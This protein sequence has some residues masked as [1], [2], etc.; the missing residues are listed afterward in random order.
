MND[1]EFVV[2]VKLMDSKKWVD[3][4]DDHSSNFEGEQHEAHGQRQKCELWGD[5]KGYHK[6]MNCKFGG[7]RRCR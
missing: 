4:K 3:F 7:G 5:F 6:C 1:A 2:S